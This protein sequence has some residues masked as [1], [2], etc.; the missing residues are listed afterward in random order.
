MSSNRFPIVLGDTP[1]TLADRLG[2]LA[3][4]SVARVPVT[5]VVAAGR[6]NLR[7]PA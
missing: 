3:S 7:P 4:S 6:G 1:I 2:E 5:E